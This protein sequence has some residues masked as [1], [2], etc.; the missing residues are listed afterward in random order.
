[1]EQSVLKA[2]KENDNERAVLKR[3]DD[4]DVWADLVIYNLTCWVVLIDFNNFIWL[5]SVDLSRLNFVRDKNV[6]I[7]ASSV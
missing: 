3:R 6:L 2:A 1:M 7:A 5:G 4:R